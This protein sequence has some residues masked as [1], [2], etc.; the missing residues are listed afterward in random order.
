MRPASIQGLYD[1]I[2]SGRV[3]GFTVPAFNLRGL[4]RE[5]A[6]A[7]FRAARRL[8][9]GAFVFEISRG[10]MSYTAIRPAEFSAEVLAAAEREG[11][12]GPVFLQGDHFQFD[13]REY[14]SD[15]A[16]ETARI[17]ALTKE[18][19]GAGF[20]N[21]DIDASTLVRLDRPTAREQQR[22]NFERTAEMTEFI[23][24]LR[25]EVSV[26]GEIG[27]VGKENSTVE[28]FEA[29]FEGYR[30]R[31]K[32]KPIS[33]MSVQTG[34]AHGGVVNPDGSRAAVAL[35]FG[36]LRSISAACRRRG[37]AG[38]VQHGASTL[39]DEMLGEFPRNDCVEI[40][41]ATGFQQAIFNHPR[42][43][44]ELRE[45]QERWVEERRP[46]EWRAGAT[47]AQNFEKAVKRTWGAL[48]GEFDALPAETVDPIMGTLEGKYGAAMERLGIRGTKALVEG[49]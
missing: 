25:P 34:T 29:F 37:L 27:E 16:A 12:T 26:G 10:E 4:V 31:W 8:E 44:K 17:K 9:A 11:W 20:L 18:A 23:R 48:K 42:F 43:P 39:P 1:R 36:V 2:A 7:I 40:H 28:E 47:P 19:V 15:P 14:A 3:R 41:L 13:P 49:L 45:K 46:P 35:D 33:K 30:E 21:I 22:E 6:R 5:T 38:T 32:G 24:A